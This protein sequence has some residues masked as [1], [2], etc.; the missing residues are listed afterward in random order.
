MALHSR[1]LHTAAMSVFRKGPFMMMVMLGTAV[2]LRGQALRLP[3]PV[4]NQA[5]ALATRDGR[6]VVY[7]FYGL[8]STLQQ[9]GIH[10]KVFRY[11]IGT[12]GS[13]CVGMVPDSVGRLASSASTIRDQVYL[14]GG[15]S[16]HASGKERSSP[17][18]LR[19]D[20]AT[21]AFHR[22]ADLPVPIDDHVQAVWRDSILFVMSGWN[23]SSNVRSVQ[24]YEP[25]KNRWSMAT[26]LPAERDA[27]VFGGCGT[28]VGDTIYML[29]GAVFDKFYPPSGSLYKGHI[30][31]SH[32]ANIEWLPGI[33]FPGERRYRSVAFAAGGKLFFFGGSSV[34]YNYNGISYQDM[35]PVDP[36]KT[37]LVYDI[38]TGIFT[39][40]LAPFQVMDLRNGV[41]HGG[42]SLIVVGGIGTGQ[43]VSDLIRVLPL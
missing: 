5:V 41:I 12:G 35:T 16:V 36:N 19:F 10:R 34:T 28:I 42:R 9:P 7:T 4:T 6:P 39:S 1:S 3:E 11:D 2:M 40:T 25:S 15:Y 26:S 17:L 37:M 20:P 27:A 14:C 24:M 33:P 8:D 22:C 38:A 18:L 13:K 32:P 30:D 31:P 21:E 29:G 43:R 23:D